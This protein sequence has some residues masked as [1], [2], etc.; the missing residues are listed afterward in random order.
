M[1][2]SPAALDPVRRV[3]YRLQAQKIYHLEYTLQKQGVGHATVGAKGYSSH[4]AG[5]PYKLGEDFVLGLTVVWE[6]AE[7]GIP[8][9]FVANQEGRYRHY[10][11]VAPAAVV[12]PCHGAVVEEEVGVRNHEFGEGLA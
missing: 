9:V 8:E 12:E 2:I 6:G 7:E 11:V 1:D 10:R 4:E 3:V 5:V